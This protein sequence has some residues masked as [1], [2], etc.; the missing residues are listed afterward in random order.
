MVTAI[1]VNF[2]TPELIRDCVTTFG[3]FY[4]QIP[5]ILIDNGGCQESL[6]VMRELARKPNIVLIEN[7]QNKGHGPGLHQGILFA[8]T[9]YVFT[10]D[11]DTRVER[12]EFL[13]LMLG[14]FRHDPSLF[15]LGWLRY[16]N[17][18]GVASPRQELKR[19]MEYVHPYACLLDRGKYLKLHPFIH[20]GAPATRLMS[21][22]KRSGYRL[23]SFP[24]ERYIWHKVAG[25][26]GC[27]AGECRVPTNA[28]KLPW[29]KH[30]I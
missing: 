8:A 25:T 23:A 28:R 3:K 24:I 29:R 1:T 20:S 22:A 10:L 14:E 26:R 4:P 18:S 19:G 9:K 11:S 17:A 6:R 21:S 15:A 27:F 16:T 30:R 7:Q 5:H 12:G 2:R 13:E